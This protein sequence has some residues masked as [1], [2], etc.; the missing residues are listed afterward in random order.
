MFNLQSIVVSHVF[1]PALLTP[2]RG[3]SSSS[4]NSTLAAAVL[5]AVQLSAVTAVHGMCVNGGP[6]CYFLHPHNTL[7]YHNHPHSMNALKSAISTFTGKDE[8]GGA[9][10]SRAPSSR[11]SQG[12]AG[13]GGQAT[14]SV[15]TAGRGMASDG[16]AR[17]TLY[18]RAFTLLAFFC[19]LIVSVVLAVFQTKWIGG[20]SGLTG[21]LLFSNIA[22][23]L[24]VAFFAAVPLLAE[25]TG[26]KKLTDLER[27]LRENRVGFVGNGFCLT[28][29]LI[30]ALTQLIS[31]LTAKGC[32]DPSRD[33]HAKSSKGKEADYKAALGEFCTSKRAQVA[34]LWIGWLCFVGLGALFL[35]SFKQSRKGGPRIPPFSA[36][37]TDGAFQALDGEDHDH[38]VRGDGEDDD[39]YGGYKGYGYE[40]NAYP[41]RYD[42]HATQAPG[43]FNYRNPL[44]D[45][46]ARYGLH[47]QPPNSNAPTHNPFADALAQARPMSNAPNYESR[48]SYDYGA[49]DSR[50]HAQNPYDAV[51]AHVGGGYR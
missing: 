35:L 11:Y 28:L 9:G 26:G 12:I 19:S 25:R 22:F 15:S 40:D 24:I 33:P 45:I 16:L 31:T 38:D 4:R 5:S 47:S 23:I 51:Q 13:G 32:K 46:E 48:Q 37:E 1:R 7:S 18:L 10:A 20:P 21:F 29:G 49:Y 41:A 3:A 30:V 50:P 8:A 6:K 42:D 36:G 17:Y 34:F 27:A 43:A 44:S 2:N 39:P 14:G